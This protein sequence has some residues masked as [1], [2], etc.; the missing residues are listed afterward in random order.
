MPVVG[1]LRR[2]VPGYCGK[3]R[4]ISGRLHGA[5][6][7]LWAHVL[8]KVDLRLLSGEVDARG[9]PVDPVE[10]VLDPGC[11]R[12]TA[13]TAEREGDRGHARTDSIIMFVII[14]P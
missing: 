9:N 13:H 2:N 14:Y 8:R 10:R 7:I 3:R 6:Q 4:A 11:A 12:G 1:H 5:Y